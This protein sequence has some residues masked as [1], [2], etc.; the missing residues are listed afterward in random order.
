MA[1]EKPTKPEE[2]EKPASADKLLK[3]DEPD[4]HVIPERFYGATA[5]SKFKEPTPPPP[6]TPGVPKLEAPKPEKPI[7]KFPVAIVVIVVLLLLG[8]GVT[9]YFLYFADKGE[10]C[11]DGTCAADES[12]ESCPEDCPEPGAVCG[13]DKCE[14]PENYNTCPQDC[15]APTVCGDGECE[16]GEDYKSCPGDCEAPEAECGNGQCEEDLGETYKNCPKDCMPPEPDQAFDTDSDGLTDDE[17]NLIYKSD[18]NKSNSDGDSFVDLNEVLNLF[19]PAKPDPAML[20]D[21]PG[22]E[23]YSNAEYGIELYRPKLWSVREIVAER[24]VHFTSSTG[25]TF[26]VSIFEKSAD[27]SLMNWYLEQPLDGFS[28]GQ[29]E[30]AVSRKGYDQIITANRRNVYV[31]DGT[32]VVVLRYDLAD[33]LEI[34]YRVTLTMMANS[35]TI[36][37]AAPVEAS[38][39]DEDTGPALPVSGEAEEEAEEEPPPEEPLV[40][41]RE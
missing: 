7:K 34:R 23:H 33:Q 17:E 20:I 10:V 9:T 18:R 36:T 29:V 41:E 11:G 12:Y 19:D 22:I 28:E 8:G 3:K 2:F 24:T 25:E 5:K 1:E 35:L 32:T 26:K 6:S 39:E 40:E 38:T 31:S 16:A 30:Q 14:A 15:E 4:I 27:K 21:N 13:D 37:K